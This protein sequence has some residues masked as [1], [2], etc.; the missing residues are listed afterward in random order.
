MS[1]IVVRNV[2]SGAEQLVAG[3]S[4][5]NKQKVDQLL[6]RFEDYRSTRRSGRIEE[7]RR[8]HDSLA[9]DLGLLRESLTGMAAMTAGG[10]AAGAAAGA[11]LFGIGALAGG[12]IGAAVGYIGSK[13]RKEEGERLCDLLLAELGPRP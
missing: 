1:D 11:W 13:Q 9:N 4:D 10:A 3:L 6:Q 5:D 7:A 8:Q 2:P 12:A